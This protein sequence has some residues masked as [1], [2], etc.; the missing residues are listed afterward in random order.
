MIAGKLSHY[1]VFL[2]MVLLELNGQYP[3]LNLL[4][5]RGHGDVGAKNET[6]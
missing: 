2:V 6:C 5:L 3:V 4:E 1:I